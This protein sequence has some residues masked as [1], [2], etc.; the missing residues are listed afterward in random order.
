MIPEPADPAGLWARIGSDVG[1]PA[2]N[3]DML[4]GLAGGWRDASAGLG[5]MRDMDYSPIRMAWAD[6]AGSAFHGRATE[7]A[8]R[9]GGVSDRMQALARHAEMFAGE[10]TATKTAIHDTVMANVPAWQ[11]MLD[12][13]EAVGGPLRDIFAAQLTADLRE[14]VEASAGRIRA[15]G[16]PDFDDDGLYDWIADAASEAGGTFDDT[17]DDLGDFIGDVVTDPGAALGDA[18]AD[19][20]EEVGDAGAAL[21]EEVGETVDDAVEVLGEEVR[22]WQYWTGIGPDPFDELP[23]EQQR[24]LVDELVEEHRFGAAAL[25]PAAAEYA[26]RGGPPGTT[27]EL[28]GPEASGADITYR[29]PDG[30]AA[31][32]VEV[33]SVGGGERS[34]VSELRHALKN[35]LSERLPD[36]TAEVLVQVPPGTSTDDLLIAFQKSRNDDQLYPYRNATLTFVDPE[37]DLIAEYNVAERLPR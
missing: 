15:A 1:W 36:R 7:T 35:Q 19:L 6:P 17:A 10:V 37:G 3:E 2:S 18:G 31:Y 9:V 30:D 8:D 12:M 20:G 24:R 21:G 25:T 4:A 33:K 5:A 27:I 32:A 13:P 22:D 11:A 34:F 26:L 28:T 14:M 23:P 29:S 16:P